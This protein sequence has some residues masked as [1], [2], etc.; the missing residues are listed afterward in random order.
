MN[1][2]SLY[3]SEIDAVR[4]DAFDYYVFIRDAWTQNRLHQVR[5]ARGEPAVDPLSED[6][7]YFLDEFEDEIF[8]EDAV[9]GDGP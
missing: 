2:R 5:E 7:L 4:A 9:D 1:L 6:D 8:E 3:L